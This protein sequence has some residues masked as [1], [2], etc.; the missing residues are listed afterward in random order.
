LTVSISSG[1]GRLNLDL[2]HVNKEVRLTKV[3][4]KLIRENCRPIFN[5]ILFWVRIRLKIGISS[6]NYIPKSSEV[7]R[8]FMEVW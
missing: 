1:K 8:L 5:I 4:F 6:Y 2:R 3:K 7:S